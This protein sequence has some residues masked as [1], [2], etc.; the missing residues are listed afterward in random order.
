AELIRLLARRHT[1]LKTFLLDQ[2]AIAGIG[3]IYADEICFVARLLPMRR[4][5]SLSPTE[6]GRLARAIPAV[7]S[8]AVDQRGSSLRDGRYRDLFGGLGDYQLL[9]AV[10]D[11]AGAPCG[12]CGGIVERTRVAG[13]STYYCPKCQH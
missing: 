1:A 3:N 10:H 2:S 13:R 6:I 8:K 4:T 5:E 12:S 11:R 7:L 9:H